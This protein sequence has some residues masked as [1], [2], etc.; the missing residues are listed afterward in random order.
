MMEFARPWLLA[1]LPFVV[2]VAWWRSRGVP[3][4]GRLRHPH[5]ALFGAGVRGWRVRAVSL[6][7]WLSA[8]GV[9]LLVVAA[10]GPRQ[11]HR[12]EEVEGEGTDIVLALDISGSMQSLDFQPLDRLE[13]AKA[14]IREF[15]SGRPHDQIGLV[16]FAARAFTQC[17]LTLDH[18]VLTSFLDEIRIGLVDDGTAIGL[19]LATAVSR[20]QRSTSPSRTII[21]L[22]DGVNN[23]PTL[24]P[25]TAAR[26]AKT[27]GIRVYAVAIGR[28]GMVPFPV[29]D[30][31][32]GRRTRQ[33]ES[34]I[35]LALL[36]RI[37]DTTGGAMFQATDPEALQNIF[38]KIDE[39]EKVRFRTTV[40]TWYRE[41]MAWFAVPGLALLLAEAL[42]AATWLRR[43]P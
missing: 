16:V 21:L 38:R 4:A 40:S 10:S 37:A 41:R 6:L 15:I 9:A 20:L 12:S 2:A 19:G 1:A 39:M 26:L 24:E 7:P 27:F 3:V 22:T 29:E 36:R 13:S 33:I 28:E 8:L 32:F 31:I 11:A 30:P 34:K 23:V 43:L 35:D 18:P 14:V 42:L 5:V 17:P 25:E